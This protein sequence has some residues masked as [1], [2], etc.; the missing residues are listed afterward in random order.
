MKRRNRSRRTHLQPDPPSPSR[1]P[2]GAELTRAGLEV[3][4]N[5]LPSL[6][7]PCEKWQ[8]CR[9][10]THPEP[11]LPYWMC[12][13]PTLARDCLTGGDWLT[14]WLARK[15]SQSSLFLGFHLYIFFLFHIFVDVYFPYSLCLFL[16]I[17]Y[18][19]FCFYQ[20]ALAVEINSNHK[21]TNSQYNSHVE[22]RSSRR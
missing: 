11:P 17:L 10:G 9:P 4:T 12:L 5:F 6:V 19:F 20:C 8:A 7:R 21:A 3:N 15:I 13:G 2:P 14:D 16:C 1:P 22:S 18:L